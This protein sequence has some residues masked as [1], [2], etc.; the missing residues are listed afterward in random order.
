M[1]AQVLHQLL[2]SNMFTPSYP[3]HSV[4]ITPS[5]SYKDNAYGDLDP[6]PVLHTSVRSIMTHAVAV[7]GTGSVTL[8][9][10]LGLQEVKTRHL[11]QREH[12]SMKV[13]LPYSPVR[14]AACAH[15]VHSMHSQL[16]CCHLVLVAHQQNVSM[17]IMCDQAAGGLQGQID[18]SSG[19]VM[20]VKRCDFQ[21]HVNSPQQQ[22]ACESAKRTSFCFMIC[23]D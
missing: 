6:H 3:L 8:R 12:A 10:L 18:H 22:N 20:L 11:L 15:A 17:Q 16:Y 13:C 19:R 7:M 5:G 1:V 9:G 23:R 4:I 14:P 21:K 2:V